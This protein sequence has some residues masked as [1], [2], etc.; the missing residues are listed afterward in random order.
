MSKDTHHSRPMAFIG[1]TS[2]LMT[3]MTKETKR[4]QR[5]MVRTKTR[6]KTQE[7]RDIKRAE[8]KQKAQ[9]QKEK[10]WEAKA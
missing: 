7:P 10:D 2:P 6:Q 3:N 1:F 8:A 4:A 9:A 5:D